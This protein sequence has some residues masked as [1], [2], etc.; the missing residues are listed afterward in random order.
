MDAA[1][2]R[3]T[4]LALK[5]ERLRDAVT[6]LRARGAHLDRTKTFVDAQRFENAHGDYCSVRFDVTPFDGLQSAR[7]V[8]DAY[9]NFA[10]NM[11]INVSATL[12]DI[13][14]REDDDAFADANDGVSHHRMVSTIANSVQLDVNSVMFSEFYPNGCDLSEKSPDNTSAKPPGT[15]PELGVIVFDVVDDDARYPYRSSER[16]RQDVTCFAM[17]SS[18]R[19]KKF[20]SDPQRA[21]SSFHN[22]VLLDEDELVVVLERW[23]LLRVHRSDFYIPEEIVARI[24]SGIEHVADAI[25]T[26]VRQAVYASA[27]AVVVAAQPRAPDA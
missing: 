11:E 20:A 22:R 17:V 18:F 3:A 14:I 10:F 1:H 16:V 15:T 26:T 25:L 23:S 7:Q 19:R 27:S 9:V 5:S 8:F 6:F 4:L 21:P 12:G 24:K 2:R 13:T